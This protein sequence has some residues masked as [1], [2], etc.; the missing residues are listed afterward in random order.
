MKKTTCQPLRVIVVHDDAA[1]NNMMKDLIGTSLAQRNCNFEIQSI[2]SMS[3]NKL[4]ECRPD[5]ICI[6]PKKTPYGNGQ[7]RPFVVPCNPV[8]IVKNGAGEVYYDLHAA[9]QAF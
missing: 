6:P 8:N 4:R 7:T 9:F 3:V 1:I 5:I 2:P